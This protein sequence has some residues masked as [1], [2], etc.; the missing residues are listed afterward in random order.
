MARSPFFFSGA[1][2]RERIAEIAKQK[3][4]AESDLQS[5]SKARLPSWRVP[6]G[7]VSESTIE[8]AV[9]IKEHCQFHFAAVFHF[10]CLL[11]PFVCFGAIKSLNMRLS[12]L[13]SLLLGGGG[14]WACFAAILQGSAH[15][16]T[17]IS[18]LFIFAFFAFFFFLVP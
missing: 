6:H 2:C 17:S 10:Y 4:E 3:V 14:V 18:I 13:L 1:I 8:A 11:L 9:H 5:E 12:L 7:C 16:E 15:P